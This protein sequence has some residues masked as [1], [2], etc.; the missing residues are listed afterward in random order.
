MTWTV[1]ASQVPH[2]RSIHVVNRISTSLESF[3]AALVTTMPG[4]S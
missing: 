2:L 1:H 4:L 3:A